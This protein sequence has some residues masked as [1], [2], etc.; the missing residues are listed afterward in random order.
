MA[1]AGPTF[2]LSVAKDAFGALSRHL[3][4]LTRLWAVSLLPPNL[5]PCGPLPPSEA[6]V[7]SEFDWKASPFGL[8]FQSVTLPRDPPPERLR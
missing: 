3:G 7:G 1:A 5:T 4:A 8:N 6:I 2:P